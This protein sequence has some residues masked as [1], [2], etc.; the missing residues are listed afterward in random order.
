MIHGYEDIISSSKSE[1]TIINLLVSA[2][3]VMLT[4]RHAWAR[5]SSGTKLLFWLVFVGLFNLAG[6]LTYLALNHT[7]VI[8]CPP[9]GKKRGLE[10]VDCVR[11]GA[12]LPR[13]EPTVHD[14]IFDTSLSAQGPKT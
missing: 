6:L 14:L 4:L 3:M 11:C 7:P 8:K 10:R 5:R 12:E 2:V 13:P 9:C 1:S